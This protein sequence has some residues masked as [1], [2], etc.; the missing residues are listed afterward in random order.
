[1]RSLRPAFVLIGLTGS[2]AMGKSTAAA[3]RPRNVRMFDSDAIVRRLMASGGAA[4]QPVAAQFPHV[5]KDG[6]IDTLALGAEV[7]PAPEKLKKLEAILHPLVKVAQRAFLR[8]VAINRLKVA[9]ID[10]PLLFETKSE[11]RFDVIAV[12]S[13]PFFLQW[14]RVLKR[15]GQSPEKA[16]A[17]LARQVPD[18]IKRRGA[19]VVILTG[20]GKRFTLLRMHHMCRRPV[21]ARHRRKEAIRLYA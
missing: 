16:R 10:I 4:V 7:F 21:P 19:D 18:R 2:V 9:L 3:L 12:V 20:L 11:A 5:L 6:R 1:M 14:Q 15:P 8:Q 13:A 17:V